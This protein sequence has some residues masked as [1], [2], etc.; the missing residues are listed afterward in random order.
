VKEVVPL[1][2]A[3]E[4]AIFGSKA[5]GLGEAE[6]AGLPVPPGVALSGPIVEAVAAGEDRAIAKVMKSVRGLVG[7]SLSARRPWTRMAPRP[8]LPAST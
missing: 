4:T 5:V 3:R 8:A 1:A 7:R 2:K 6:R